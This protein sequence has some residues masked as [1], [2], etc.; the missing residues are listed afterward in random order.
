MATDHELHVIFGTGPLGMAVMQEL[1]SRGK[2]VRIVNRSG[3]A[4]VPAAIEVVKAD[5]TDPVS[6]RAACRDAAVIYNCTKPPYTE[7][8]DKFPPI[9]N[10]IIDGAQQAGAKLVYADNLYMYGQVN[11]ALTETLPY[12]AT[13]HKGRTRAQMATTLMEAHTAGKV[14][15][16]ICRASDFFGPGVLESALGERVFAAA[17]AGKP[18]EVLGALDFPHT[19]TYIDDFARALVTMG[20]REEALGQVWHSPSA[21]TITTRQFLNMVYAEAGQTPKFRVAPRALVTLLGLFSPTMR[22]LKEMLYTFEQPFVVD[23]RKYAQA[24]GDHTTPH[25]VAIR[26]TLAWYRGRR[27]PAPVR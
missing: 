3:R 16:A 20:E 6:T 18:A 24:F 17:I 2:R 15:V 22:E 10:G 5:A 25:A 14:R 11:G 1:L 27:G 8:P 12:K 19:Y 21:E 9:M 13:G 23:H 26:Q 4:E 7:W